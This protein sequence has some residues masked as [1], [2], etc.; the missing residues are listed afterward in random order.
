[1][2]DMSTTKATPLQ[3]EEKYNLNRDLVAS[4]RLNYQ[5]YLW[6]DAFGYNL[7]P[8]IAADIKD[9]KDLVVADIAT[10]TGIWLH[11]IARVLPST[12]KFEGLDIDLAQCPPAGWTPPNVSYK[13]CDALA[14][15]PDNMLARY[16]VIH[17]R[18]FVTVVRGSDPI[19]LVE[20]LISML[21]PGGWIQW[22][23]WDI[24]TTYLTKAD[25]ETPSENIEKIGRFLEEI[26]TTS[27]LGNWAPQLESNFIQA[28]LQDTALEKHLQPPTQLS[29]QSVNVMV[30]FGEMLDGLSKAGLWDAQKVAEVKEVYGAAIQESKAGAVLQVAK[31]MAKPT[32]KSPSSNHKAKHLSNNSGPTLVRWTT[33]MAQPPSTTLLDLLSINL[34]LKQT[35]PYLPIST[36]LALAATNASFKTLI[37]SQPEAWR[38]LDL[39]TAKS[40]IIDTS[41][42][43]T[44][45][46]SWR[47]ERMDEALT[48]DDFYSGPLRGTF[49]KLHN[50]GVLRH[51]HTLVLDGLSVPADLVRE[52]IAEE[53]FNVKI[54]SLRECKN[55]NHSK[56]QQVLR[57][58]FR[59]GRPENT[60]RLRG[61]Y[62]F[63]RRDATPN[64]PMQSTP[65]SIPTHH[66]PTGVLASQG[67]Q[68]GSE[69]NSRSSATL[70]QSLPSDDQ[71]RWYGC[72][73]RVL[74][75]PTVDWAYT[76][77]N[78]QE[79]LTFDAVL[80]R[81]PRHDIS[82]ASGKGYLDPRVA[83][84]A[85]G[86]QGCESCGGC[87]E[88]PA[89]F[90]QTAH[91]TLPLLAPPPTHSSTVRAAQKPEATNAKSPTF[92]ARCGD[93]LQGRWC[94]R[95]N[96]WWCESC[97]QEPVPSAA[98]SSQPSV[99]PATVEPSTG[100]SMAPPG[101]AI[102]VYSKLCVEHCLVG[103]MMISADGF[104]G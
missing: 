25:P 104:W 49:S 102:K 30:A 19:K 43:D 53:R 84:V 61:L 81:G 83:N 39:S 56:L 14:P 13:Q 17:L 75:H 37:E 97:Y 16:D 77:Y 41:P 60:T 38:Y 33:E 68:I 50:K 87:P 100:A 93:C 58:T 88:E 36:L 65:T 45:G 34:I 1:M 91:Y 51:V 90:G 86:P 95:C 31:F 62:I 21:R 54:L 63:G 72:S 7:H 3:A 57:Y 96:R 35:A 73:G 74:T 4:M 27:K 44:G 78:C 29:Y 23:E 48:E 22:S 79:V 80:C 10:G 9:K 89:V 26:K 28:G 99:P 67:A 92:I 18:H 76:L 103:E 8:R 85:L 12:T 64:P 69:W 94:E 6:Q 5:H 59:P 11:D 24:G 46:I 15:A 47:A 82:K 55:L 52:I 20:S 42:I 98:S 66:P 101:A 71:Q 2:G 40:A 70:N 32:K